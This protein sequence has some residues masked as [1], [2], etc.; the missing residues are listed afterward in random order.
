MWR[1]RS[2]APGEC[3]SSISRRILRENSVYNSDVFSDI[4][5]TFSGRQVKCHRLIICSASEYFN[6]LCGQNSPWKE[7]NGTIE[8]KD[9][10]PVA[11]EAMLRWIYGFTYWQIE[12]ILKRKGEIAFHMNAFVT[13][14]KYMLNSLRQSAYSYLQ[15][16]IIS[17]EI[18]LDI[19]CSKN[20]QD[21]QEVFEVIKLLCKHR[22]HSDEFA[23]II[24][25]LKT[26][27]LAALFKVKVFRASLET[28]EE[29]KTL[30]QLTKA[31]DLGHDALRN[32]QHD[33]E[34]ES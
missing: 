32:M 23:T 8:L 21:G 13:A 7:S 29:N 26:N 31:V 17:L 22:E 1:H 34:M 5:I 6:A 28:D 9:D 2:T 3:R 18:S 14:Q 25:R 16:E 15:G 10:E 19:L 12:T 4:T 11:V 33:M 27:H 24:E 30:L 20:S